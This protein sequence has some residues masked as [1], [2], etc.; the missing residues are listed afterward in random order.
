M[1]VGIRELRDHLSQYLDRVRDG[2]ELVVTD[3]G[4]AVARLVP[5]SGERTFDRLVSE[6]LIEPAPVPQR[7]RPQRRV[8]SQATVSDLVADQRR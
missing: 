5:V 1:E 7:H 6:G 3:R 8:T 2:N 4:R